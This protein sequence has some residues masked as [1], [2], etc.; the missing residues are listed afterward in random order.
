MTRHGLGSVHTQ[1]CSCLRQN[2][3]PRSS[4]ALEER[5][6]LL[7]GPVASDLKHQLTQSRR[8]VTK[9]IQRL[10]GDVAAEGVAH[11]VRPAPAPRELKLYCD[12]VADD[13]QLDGQFVL[14]FA[15]QTAPRSGPGRCARSTTRMGHHRVGRLVQRQTTAHHPRQR[16]ARRVRGWVL[17][18][19]R[20]AV[21]PGG[22][23]RKGAPKNRGRF[24]Q[25]RIAHRVT[26]AR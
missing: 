4:C 25:V 13:A 21:P 24:T 6:P 12:G 18:W 7:R 19:P 22:G 8:G 16:P 26:R 9:L 20:N 14:V 11:G 23:T 10:L 5:Q 2:E 17:R 3:R 15:I 1:L